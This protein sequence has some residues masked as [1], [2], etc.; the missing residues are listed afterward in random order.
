MGDNVTQTFVSGLKVEFGR[1]SSS[2]NKADPR[3]AAF[4]RAVR[5]MTWQGQDPNSD[6]LLYGLEYRR[7]DEKS[8]RTIVEE[9][10]EQLGS[11]DT[12]E[13]PDG[14]YHVRVTASDRLD[15]PG[16][17]ALSHTKEAG[18]LLVDNTPPEISRF[19]LEKIPTG[20]RI[21]FRAQDKASVLSQAFIRLPDGREQRLDPVDRICD[22][23]Q[24][25]F[26]TEI[27]WPMSHRQAGDE[28]WQVRVEVW[29]LLGNSAFSEG[30][31]Q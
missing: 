2:D 24:E 22:S 4:T 3:R 31:A 25:E 5:I 6:R 1:K 14:S 8:W 26:R 27:P 21:S 13:I 20:L 29:D 23:R 17:L 7:Q 28:P 12:G 9:T 19:K 15:N 30:E 16:A 10:P 18:P 11:W